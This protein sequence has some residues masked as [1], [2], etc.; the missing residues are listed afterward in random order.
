MAWSRRGV[1][2]LLDL[3][4][5]LVLIELLAGARVDGDAADRLG[6][7]GR[8]DAAVLFADARCVWKRENAFTRDYPIVNRDTSVFT[9]CFMLCRAVARNR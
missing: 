5:G 2:G 7:E 1:F 6:R 8:H 3:G 9:L 4:L